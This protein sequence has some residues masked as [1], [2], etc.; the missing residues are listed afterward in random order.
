MG[1]SQTHLAGEHIELQIKSLLGISD[2]QEVLHF[3]GHEAIVEVYVVNMDC[4]AVGSEGFGDHLEFAVV[5][6]DLFNQL[7]MLFLELSQHLLDKELF[8]VDPLS[9]IFDVGHR[10]VVELKGAIESLLGHEVI[11]GELLELA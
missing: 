2:L 7:L 6:S 10:W 9:V 3:R 5:L 1:V 8:I 11:K 4:V